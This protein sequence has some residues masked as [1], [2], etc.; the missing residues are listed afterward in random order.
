MKKYLSPVKAI[1]KFCYE[2]VGRSAKERKLCSITDCP[3]YPFRLG[4]NP[5]RKGIGGRKVK[6]SL[7]N[8]KL[9]QKT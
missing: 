1:K 8:P 2:C 9:A 4:K 3:L 6:E 7:K 5:N